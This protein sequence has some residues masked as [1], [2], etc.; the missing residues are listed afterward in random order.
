MSTNIRVKQAAA[1]LGLQSQRWISSAILAEGHVTSSSAELW[2]MT[3]PT[4]TL[5]ATSGQQHPLGTPLT[6]IN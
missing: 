4:W 2:S 1:Y 3:L 5:G 6:A